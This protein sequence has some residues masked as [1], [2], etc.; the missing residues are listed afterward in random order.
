MSIS[1]PNDRHG[2]R[3]AFMEAFRERGILPRDVRTIS[4]E[5]L[6]WNA[7]EDPQPEW[8]GELIASIDLKW[9]R[10]LSRSKI[11]ALNEENRA[12]MWRAMNQIFRKHPRLYGEFGLV[13]GLPRYD[14]D[15]SELPKRPGVGSNFEVF[16]VRPARRVGP[17]GNLRNEVIAIIQQRRPEPIDGKDMANGWFW[18]RGGAT[19]ILDTREEQ[20]GDP[21]QHRQEHGQ[22]D[23]AGAAEEGR[24]GQLPVALRALY[25]GDDGAEP[26]AMMHADRKARGPWLGESSLLRQRS[27]PAVAGPAARRTTRG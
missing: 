17:D 2:Y 8:L 18:F 3:V 9:N 22:H 5:S 1:S 15:G 13:P 14:K 10:N 27:A 16:S 23:A 26:F 12:S 4:T 25:F 7:P 11:F 19:L 21:L 24:S 20:A 6:V